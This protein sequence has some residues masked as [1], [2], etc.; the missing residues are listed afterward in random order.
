M[1][2]KQWTPN[3]KLDSKWNI[4]VQPVLMFHSSFTNSIEFR[5]IPYT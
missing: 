1:L 3:S 4:Q 5:D 2:T